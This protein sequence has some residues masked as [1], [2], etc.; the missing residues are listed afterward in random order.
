[1]DLTVHTSTLR[2]CANRLDAN[3]DDVS[4]AASY[5]AQ[6]LNVHDT[7]MF[8]QLSHVNGEVRAHLAELFKRLEAV[9]HGSAAELRATARMYD[10][11]DHGVAVAMD[12]KLAEV[13]PVP[14]GSSYE[15]VRDDFEDTTPVQPDDWEPPE[16]EEPGVEVSPGV[17]TGAGGGGGGGS[18]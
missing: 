14:P 6:H 9:G 11:T 8:V 10:H 7:G 18:W 3:A 15:D 5:A 13:G 2:A 16:P 17:P 4:V 1:M 12:R